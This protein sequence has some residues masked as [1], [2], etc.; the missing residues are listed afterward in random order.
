MESQ[1]QTSEN[2]SARESLKPVIICADDYGVDPNVDLAIVELAR[3]ARLSATS[4]LVD[5][6]ISEGSVSALE[7]IDIDIGLHL[8]FTEVFGQ[9]S[10]QSV[11]PLSKLIM[12]AHARLLPRSWVRANIERQLGRFEALFGRLPDYVDGHLHVHQLPV[13]RDELIEALTRR[14][15]PS[16]FWVRDTRAGAMPGWPWSER[17]KSWVIGHLGMPRLASLVERAQL[18]RNH[19]F[20]GVYDFTRAH[21]PFMQMLDDWL[22]QAGEGAL[23]MTHPARQVVANDPIGQARVA[24]YEGLASDDFLKL[25]QS[26]H[27]RLVRASQALS[28]LP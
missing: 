15:L 14:Q 7:S 28:S 1:L 10:P 6:D 12:R 20:F 25:L 21:R 18:S 4:V 11:M 23:I 26:R 8:N 2:N 16:G 9:L 17:F 3:Q 19:G 22:S 24:E 27:A 5:A 13:I